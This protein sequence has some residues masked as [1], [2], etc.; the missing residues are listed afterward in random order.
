MLKKFS[1]FT[2][3]LFLFSALLFT[4]CKKD[5]NNLGL[6]IQPPYDKLNVTS[7]DTT[8]VIAYS[9]IVDSVKSD[10]TSVSLLG[11]LADPVF[12]TSTASIFTQFRL[13][14]SA[15]DFGESPVADSLILKLR[16][17][18]IYGDT[19][20]AM[21]IRVFEMAGQIYIDSGYYSNSTVAVK[22]TLIGEKTFVP[23]LASNV[24]IG[25]DT[26][27]PHLRINLSSLTSVLSDKLLNAPADSM[28]SNVSFLNYFYGLYLTAEPANFGGSIIYFDL[29]SEVSEMVLYYHNNANDSLKFSYVINSSCARF[30]SFTHDYSQGDPAFKAQLID[31][32]TSLGNNTCYIQALGGVKTYVHFPHIKNYYA[33]GKIAVNEARLFLKCQETDA[34]LGL[35]TVLILVK[36]NAEGGYDILGDQLEGAGYFGGYY[37]KN[38]HGYW[39]RITSTIQ[40]LMRSED[41]DYGFEV[42]LSGGAVNAERVLLN[43]PDPLDPASFNDR[44]KLVI[45][46]TAV[47]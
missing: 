33:N 15:F 23:D 46:Y 38:I 42:Y 30:G 24:I 22:E 12:G 4:T 14:S 2:A 37:D 16:Y 39:F 21:T 17:K 29:L 35:A 5:D 19:S 10:E 3:G 34:D 47:N 40:N 31:K 26:L 20:A 11:S 25:T 1:W 27:N 32:D 36:K 44:M 13:S 43:G 9:Q 41:P 28:A 8:T 45:T 6:E 18:N 7:T